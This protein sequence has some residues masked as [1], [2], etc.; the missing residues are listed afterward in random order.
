MDAFKTFELNEISLVLLPDGEDVASL[1]RTHLGMV[2]PELCWLIA[3]HKTVS[4][5]PQRISAE[6]Q[7]CRCQYWIISC[8]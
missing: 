4:D 3:P 6:L 7:V 8:S 2:A 5:N 1:P